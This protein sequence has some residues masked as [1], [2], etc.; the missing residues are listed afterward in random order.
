MKIMTSTLP[1]ELQDIRDRLFNFDSEVP[2]VIPNDETRID[3]SYT[4]SL[5]E[6]AFSLRPNSHLGNSNL[7]PFATSNGEQHS[8][9]SSTQTNPLS[10][11]PAIEATTTQR[12]NSGRDHG[13]FSVQTPAENSHSP[14]ISNAA[15]QLL[16][17]QRPSFRQDDFSD[18]WASASDTANANNSETNEEQI[19]GMFNMDLEDIEDFFDFRSWF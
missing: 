3:N 11:Q 18:F 15:D 9:T 7:L 12:A 4:A 10:K 5:A 16:E 19:T 8:A 2:D 17:A 13:L 1:R 14:H 6:G